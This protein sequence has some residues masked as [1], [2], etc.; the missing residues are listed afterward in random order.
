MATYYSKKPVRGFWCSDEDA[1]QYD[2]GFS[3]WRL[4]G[5]DASLDSVLEIDVRGLDATVFWIDELSGF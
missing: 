2:I 5:K 3:A 4:A 1:R